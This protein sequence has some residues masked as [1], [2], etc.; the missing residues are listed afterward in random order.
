M[1]NDLSG[2]LLAADTRRLVLPGWL[3]LVRP[4]KGNHSAGLITSM[5]EIRKSR[6]RKHLCPRLPP[7][8]LIACQDLS[9]QS[10]MIRER[11]N[12]KKEGRGRAGRMLIGLTRYGDGDCNRV[13]QGTACARDRNCIGATRSVLAC[14]DCEDRRDRAAR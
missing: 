2:M 8:A 3:S 5:W 14:R 13:G 12:S 9:I 10:R 1:F 4:R 7:P 11:T 6:V